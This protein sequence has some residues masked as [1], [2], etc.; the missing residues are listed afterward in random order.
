VPVLVADV[1][2]QP[3]RLQKAGWKACIT[4]RHRLRQN[5]GKVPVI[6]ESTLMQHHHIDPIDVR[7]PR[8]EE[9]TYQNPRPVSLPHRLRQFIFQMSLFASVAY[10]TVSLI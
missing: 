6:R 4:I 1:V 10:L 9:Y 3:F 2:V 8:Y 7:P 5:T